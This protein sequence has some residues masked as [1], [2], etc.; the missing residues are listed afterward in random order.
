[1]LAGHADNKGAT[2]QWHAA[3]THKLVCRPALSKMHFFC[4]KKCLRAVLCFEK[5]LSQKCSSKKSAS[6]R[7]SRHIEVHLA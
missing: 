3:G 5:L 6:Q 1:M 7:K 4:S 2:H